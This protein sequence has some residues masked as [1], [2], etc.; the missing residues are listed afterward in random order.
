MST[1]KIL[2]INIGDFVKYENKNKQVCLGKVEG[3]GINDQDQII[4]SLLGQDKVEAVNRNLVFE[5]IAC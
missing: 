3:F 1:K 2:K 4:I 5:K